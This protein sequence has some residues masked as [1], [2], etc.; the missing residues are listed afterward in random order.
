[1]KQEKIERAKKREERERS[2]ME[3]KHKIYEEE[4]SKLKEMEEQVKQRRKEESAK[5]Y[6]QLKSKREE[7]RKKRETLKERIPSAPKEEYLYKRLEAKY[8]KEILIPMLEEKKQELAKKRNQLKPI[9]HEEI[10]EHKR[11]CEFRMLEHEE[12]RMKEL[13]ER[14]LE[15]YQLIAQQAKFKTDLSAKYSL[16]QNKVKE[17]AERKKQEKKLLCNKMKNYA[18]LVKEVFAVKPSEEKVSELKQKIEQLKHPVRETRDIRKHYNLAILNDRKQVMKQGRSLISSDHHRKETIEDLVNFK[19]DPTGDKSKSVEKGRRNVTTKAKDALKKII[20]EQNSN[21][22]IKEKRKH[23]DYL[24][25]QRKKREQTNLTYG[26]IKRD[27]SADIK[28]TNLNPAERYNRIVS[29]ANI[30]EE[31]AKMKEKILF[32]RGGAEKDPEMGKDVTDMFIDAI[33]AKLSVLEQI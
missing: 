29:K 13:R 12:L 8:N 3:K 14:K 16:L 9:T 32:A 33:K 10:E 23:I 18:E 5:L 30:L 7:D 15:E 31:K 27:W 11:I 4:N 17:E 20:Y 26:E 1:M 24:G 22:S 6:E 25:E 2:F 19:E 21:T 28:N